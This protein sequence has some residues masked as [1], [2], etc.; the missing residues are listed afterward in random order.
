VT[1]AIGLVVPHLDDLAFAWVLPSL[2]LTATALVLLT[3]FAAPV[4]AGLVAT[5]WVTVVVLLRSEDRMDLLATPAAQVGFTA[6]ALALA[7]TL[8]LRTSTLRLQGGEL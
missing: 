7:A 4:T 1:A 8:V 6:A 5:V 2:G 3:W